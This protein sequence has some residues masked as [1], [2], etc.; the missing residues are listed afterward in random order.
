[1]SLRL[2]AWQIELN[3]QK[4]ELCEGIATAYR[5]NEDDFWLLCGQTSLSLKKGDIA[6]N[7]F[8]QRLNNLFDRLGMRVAPVEVRTFLAVLRDDIKISDFVR[9]V[10]AII[11]L[12][13]NPTL[14]PGR[15]EI[16]PVKNIEVPYGG[17]LIAGTRTR[18]LW[19]RNS[20]TMQRPSSKRQR[21]TPQN[22]AS[23]QAERA[24]RVSCRKALLILCLS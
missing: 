24:L 13:D 15:Y 9:R 12:I 10:D 7:T 14:N 2:S 5:E 6:G 20:L 18:S 8:P 21:R 16:I 22:L 19:Q 11:D 17:G 3:K 4:T 23:A 1:M